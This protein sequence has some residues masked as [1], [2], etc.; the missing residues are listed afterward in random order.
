MAYMGQELGLPERI[1]LFD[2]HVMRRSQ[3]DE[4]FRE[5]FLRAHAASRKIRAA[6]PVFDA[7][8]LAEGVVLVE[9]SSAAGVAG[10]SG[11]GARYAAILNLDGRSGSVAVPEAARRG[12]GREGRD[13]LRDRRVAYRE[14]IQLEEEPILVHLGN[15]R[16]PPGGR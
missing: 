16:E 11:G 7:V 13:L 8:L 1:E 14:S 15:E 2:R 9:R 3:G 10:A 4:G 12:L 5:F 6:A